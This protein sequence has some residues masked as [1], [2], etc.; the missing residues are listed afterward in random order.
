MVK[1]LKFWDVVTVARERS[2]LNCIVKSTLLF[3]NQKP[4]EKSSDTAPTLS[5][6]G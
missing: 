5:V 1:T 4:V 3:T 6:K 2:P